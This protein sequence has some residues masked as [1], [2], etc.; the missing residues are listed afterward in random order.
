MSSDDDELPDIPYTPLYRRDDAVQHNI[1]ECGRPGT[2]AE[3]AD[4]SRSPLKAQSRLRKQKQRKN[5]TEDQRNAEKESNR[6][7]NSTPQALEAD[8]QRKARARSRKTPEAL[9][10]DRLRKAKARSSQKSKLEKGDARRCQE[11]M[12]GKLKVSL[13]EETEDSIGL[14]NH[15]CNYCGAFKFKDETPTT[16]CSKG[17]I[18]LT[19][20]PRPPEPLMKL[21][22]GTSTKALVFRQHSRQINNAVCLSSIQVKERQ[23]QGFTPS[24]IFQGKATHRIGSISHNDGSTPRFVQLYVLDS[25]M[26]MIQ[27][28]ENLHLP[29]TT[30]QS[31]RT[32]IK[33]VVREI[34]GV[35]HEHN[36]FVKDFKQIL[37]LPQDEIAM[38]KVVISAKAPGNEH[39]RR[40]NAPTN[41]KELRI[42]TNSEPQDLV[43][44]LRGGGLQTIHDMNPKGRG[45]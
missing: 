15:E 16:C 27:R 17:K 9:E 8:R 32:I 39:S 25:D 45:V 35:I 34:Q 12:S 44:H 26:E 5:Q 42:V 13:L 30:S 43:I 2:S 38:G 24:V 29:A 41:L 40:Y 11:I 31:Q 10:A 36:P 21:W 1:L 7:R 14:M 4:R 20:F 23:F 22:S 28:I 6:L 19:P 33:Q 3:N 18:Q 37:E